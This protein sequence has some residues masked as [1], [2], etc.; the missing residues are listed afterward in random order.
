MV[1]EQIATHQPCRR[2]TLVAAGFWR[3]G[4]EGVTEQRTKNAQK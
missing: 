3:K 2:L 4:E 1:E